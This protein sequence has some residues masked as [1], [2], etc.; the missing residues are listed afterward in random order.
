MAERSLTQ[1]EEVRDILSVATSG[2]AFRA[3]RGSRAR[4]APVR[5]FERAWEAFVRWD[6]VLAARR[7]LVET[8]LR[9]EVSAA[10]T[11]MPHVWSPL[12]TPTLRRAGVRT[13]TVVHDGAPHPGDPTARVTRWLLR[14][15]RL[16]DAVVTLSQHV[17][18]QLAAGGVDG[19]R[20]P[21][22]FLPAMGVSGPTT[23]PPR[24]GPPR[25]LFLG[26]ILPYKG[27][28]LAIEALELL[29]AEGLRLPFTV[30]GEGAIEELR[31][32]LVAL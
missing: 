21:T 1:A 4:I 3:L 13:V 20:I 14:D 23:R 17:T 10:V 18:D 19:S 8:A 6:R 5:T 30:A 2:E 32:R 24:E 22:L 15:A 11:L 25:L 28:P 9:N 26:R 31:P 16:A 29:A 27:L 12:V 7:T